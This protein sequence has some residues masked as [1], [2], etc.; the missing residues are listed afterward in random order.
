MVTIRDIAEACGV[1]VATVSNYLNG[2]DKMSA[3]TQERIR[4]AVERYGYQPNAVAKGLRSRKSGII[5]IIVEDI[6]QFT[7][8]EIVEGVMRY[9]EDQKYQA[10]V[11]NL[12]L[13]A[14]WSDT[15]FNNES[16]IREVLEPALTELRS[17]MV[18]GIIYIAVHGRMTRILPDDLQVPAVMIYATEENASIPSIVLD[19]ENAA[20]EAV[21]YLIDHGH[22][23]IGVMAGRED[24][25]HT[26]LRL[27]G[28]RRA[29]EAH[30]LALE[31]ELV[32]YADWSRE[33]AEK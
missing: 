28:A 10:V 20:Y 13:Y 2:K 22:R 4:E 1:S 11:K 12:R 8:P 32:M 33:D 17:M 29:M 7:S 3:A 6:S 31:D 25:L 30:D 5:G 18:D 19:D 9:I 24:N 14:R 26:V 21:S 23:R 27:K 15:W 16:M